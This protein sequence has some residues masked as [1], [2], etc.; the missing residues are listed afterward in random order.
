MDDGTAGTTITNRALVSAVDQGDP[1]P[2]DDADT[3]PVVVVEAAGG[4]GRRD[5]GTAFTGFPGTGVIAW[6]FGLAMLGLFALAL[7]SRRRLVEAPPGRIA[8]D[9][10]SGRFLDTPEPFCFFKD[11]E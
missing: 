4:T 10:R 3:A 9:A 1:T 11:E 7:G 8:D 2:S 5:G 6:M